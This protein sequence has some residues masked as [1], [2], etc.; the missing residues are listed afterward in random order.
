MYFLYFRFS[1][2]DVHRG[3]QSRFWAREMSV[4]LLEGLCTSSKLLLIKLLCL[5]NYHHYIASYC[6]LYQ[7]FEAKFTIEILSKKEVVVELLKI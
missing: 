1:F 4:V 5:L 2:V 7:N 3:A 6:T